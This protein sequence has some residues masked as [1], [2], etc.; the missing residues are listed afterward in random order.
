MKKLMQTSGASQMRLWG[1]IQGITNDY[2]IAEGTLELK[3][4]EAAEVQD[5]PAET[6]G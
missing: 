2:Y 6:R 1:K 4:E 5:E 3:E